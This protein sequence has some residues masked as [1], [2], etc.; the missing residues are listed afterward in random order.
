MKYYCLQSSK[1]MNKCTRMGVK[2]DISAFFVSTS[3]KLEEE[4]NS[5]VKTK[6]LQGL[7]TNHADGQN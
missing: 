3:I 4:K 7:S 1:Y 6:I 2:L 5:R